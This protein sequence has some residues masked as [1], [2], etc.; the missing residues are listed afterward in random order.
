MVHCNTYF[1]FLYCYVPVA[2]LQIAEAVALVD[3]LQN[4]TVLDKTILPTK[5][6]NK[7]F[8]FGKGN[9]QALTGKDGDLLALHHTKWKT[10]ATK[11]FKDRCES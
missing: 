2:E 7:K 8:V 6:R 5:N 11:L 1:F 4:W 10:S 9:F 3:T